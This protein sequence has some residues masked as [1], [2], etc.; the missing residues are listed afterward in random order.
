MPIPSS[1][2]WMETV[3]VKLARADEHLQT[4]HDE[5]ADF[6]RETKRNLTLK[7]NPDTGA[8]W[9][10]FWVSTRIPQFD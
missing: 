9:L 4:F 1:L 6:V 2:P 7:V 10:V 5:L 3:D 8:K